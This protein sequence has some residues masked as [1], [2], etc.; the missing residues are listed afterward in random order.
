MKDA[1]LTSGLILWELRILK[2]SSRASAKNKPYNNISYLTYFYHTFFHKDT[3]KLYLIYWNVLLWIFS[4]W[5]AFDRNLTD[6]IPLFLKKYIHMICQYCYQLPCCFLEVL[7]QVVLLATIWRSSLWILRK[8]WLFEC[9]PFENHFFLIINQK[10][11]YRSIYSYCMFSR[12]SAGLKNCKIPFPQKCFA[13]ERYIA[14]YVIFG[15]IC[16]RL[17]FII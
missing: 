11:G 8:I 5:L 16:A 3:T 7:H 1:Y 10:V 12:N 4:D 9:L 15:N 2:F 14:N 13:F 6:F 17:T